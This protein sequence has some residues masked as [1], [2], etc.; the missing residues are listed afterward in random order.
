MD[1]SSG[2]NSVEE[3]I[4]I[5]AIETVAGNAES[6]DIFRGTVPKIVAKEET[7]EAEEKDGAA[8]REVAGQDHGEA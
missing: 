1:V 8:V 6:K 7:I 4:R 3:D 2:V 5:R